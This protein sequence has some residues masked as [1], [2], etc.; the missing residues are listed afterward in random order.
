MEQEKIID[1]TRSYSVNIA[2]GRVDSLRIRED[3]E[4]V[5]RVYEDGKIGVAGAVG[6]ADEAALAEEA[7]ARLAQNIPYP[8][9]L[10]EGKVREENAVTEIIP[11]R[12]F[13]K[14]IKH[15]IAR[16]NEQYPDFIFSNKINLEEVETDYRNSKGTHYNYK[17]NNLVSMLV[18]KEKAS[19]NIMDLDY[20]FTQK[21]YDEDAVVADIGK[22]LNVY[23]NK[24]A[25]P[26]EDLPVIIDT[27]VVQY[28]LSHLIAEMYVSGSSLFN[29]KLGQK[30]F[31]GK[32]NIL[33][34]RSPDNRHNTPFFD[35]EG[36]VNEGDK[37][38][39][40]KDG[41]F[42]GLITYKRS[43]ANFNLPLSGGA[44][45]DFD[46][47][48]SF[49]ANGFKVDAGGV[50]LSELV[51]G[52][53]IYIAVASGGDMTPDGNVATPVMLAYLYENGAL[54]GTLSNFG[55][56]A[57]L[58]DF[59]GKDLIGVAE[60]DLFEVREETVLV[61]KFKINR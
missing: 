16:L 20:C 15:L 14:T 60:N 38:Y 1:V 8:C 54:V 55:I 47:V 39:F 27:S 9:A 29:G 33:T 40:I 21:F 37:F 52:K 6:A 36:T 5:I 56:S 19:G 11:V 59:L 24:L 50:K 7:K 17:G 25:L 61:A 46:A 22:L 4:T 2:G 41:V 12:A 44:N 49:G 43:A 57:N 58:F 3:K 53:A 26:E 48:P 23:G 10:A 35:A 45:A 18:I 31:D 34:D 28:A 42:S 30:I 51:K 13:V 32:V